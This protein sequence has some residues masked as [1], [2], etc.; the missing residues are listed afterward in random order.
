MEIDQPASSPGRS[1]TLRRSLLIKLILLIGMMGTASWLLIHMPT[2]AS[3]PENAPRSPDPI[4][5]TLPVEPPPQEEPVTARR[6][7][8]ESAPSPQAGRRDGHPL[9]GRPSGSQPAAQTAI[10]R[11]VHRLDLN[12]ATQAE[13]ELLPGIGPGLAKRILDYKQSHGSYKTVQELREVKGIGE[14]RWRK[15]EPLLTV[16]ATGSTPERSA[17]QTTTHRKSDRTL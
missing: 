1:V 3:S 13:L 4:V 15:L 14:R 10:A 2:P 7:P 11:P 17:P 9:A 6:D 12:R 8:A 5:V 16:A